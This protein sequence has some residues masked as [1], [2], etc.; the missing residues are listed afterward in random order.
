MSH[1]KYWILSLDKIYIKI[2]EEFK[3]S[4]AYTRF[5][6]LHK[7]G[8]LSVR[9]IYREQNK[10]VDVLATSGITITFVDNI[11]TKL[12]WKYPPFMLDILHADKSR[13]LFCKRVRTVLTSICLVLLLVGRL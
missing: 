11:A 4:E 3:M 12:F 2:S 8:D 6:N 13:D 1:N 5:W 9:Y 10:L 7:L